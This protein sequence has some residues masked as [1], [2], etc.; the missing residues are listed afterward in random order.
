MA[1]ISVKKYILAD[2][3]FNN[4]Q[5]CDEAKKKKKKL[6]YFLT[7]WPKVWYQNQGGENPSVPWFGRSDVKDTTQF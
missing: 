2:Y 7:I 5:V 1:E 3:K 6:I 4:I